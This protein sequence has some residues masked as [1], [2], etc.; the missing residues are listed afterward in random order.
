MTNEN[1]SAPRDARFSRRQVFKYTGVAAAAVGGASLLEACGG[2]SGSGGGGGKSGGM[3]IHGATGGSAK[4]TLDAHRP[5]QNADIARCF[6]LYEPLLY[7]D[8]DYARPAGRRRVGGALGRRHRR[9]RSS[10]ARASPS[11][12]ARTSPPRT[13]CSP[14]TGWPARNPTSAGGRAGADHRLQ[15]H[16]EGRRHDG[17]HQAQD[18][19]RRA[20]LPP[21]RVH[22]RRR[23]GRLRPQEPGRHRPLQVQVVQPRQEQRLHQVRRLLGRQGQA[24]T[25]CTSRTSPTPA[26][27][28]TR[29][30]PARCRPSTTCPTT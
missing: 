24:S 6:Q 26:P 4:D 13:C 8:N 27:R 16:Q 28:S 25:R 19:V 2:G 3:L 17:R 1:G 10:C 12:T 9:G 23:P 7:W 5:V 11:T 21:R 14:S 20:R 30:R 22:L 15:R 18:A 29:S